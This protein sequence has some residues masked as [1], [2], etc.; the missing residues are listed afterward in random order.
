MSVPV[1]MFGLSEE[2]LLAYVEGT[3]ESLPMADRRRLEET[4]HE[5]PAL[6]CQLDL[7][8]GDRNAVR[9]WS[10]PPLDW[11]SEPLLSRASQAILRGEALGAPLPEDLDLIAG[12]S[13]IPRAPAIRISH[14]DLKREER[15]SFS[16]YAPVAA[17]LLLAC[18]AGFLGWKWL[19]SLPGRTSP[20]IHRPLV[21]QHPVDPDDQPATTGLFNPASDQAD[22]V[23]LAHEATRPA[24]R[25]RS[26]RG[27]GPALDSGLSV[28]I[29]TTVPIEEVLSRLDES[30]RESPEWAAD[31]LLPRVT[32]ILQIHPLKPD[33]AATSL[34]F[35]ATW[36]DHE[37]SSASDRRSELTPARIADSASALVPSET[38][39]TLADAGVR[40]VIVGR[41]SVIMRSMRELDSLPDLRTD[42]SGRTGSMSLEQLASM[43]PPA[44]RSWADAAVLWSHGDFEIG[45]GL[46]GPIDE[47]IIRVNLT[48]TRRIQRSRLQD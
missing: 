9:R 6:K 40:Y 29:E 13:D 34:T 26:N 11:N 7:L 39:V 14:R 17:S 47:P 5:I 21:Q 22:R 41:P 25:A 2:I 31:A 20:E 33:V 28:R 3:L 19:E 42:A 48:V 10:S 35:C 37:E 23:R 16:R 18:T 27:S 46:I 8:R 12:D 30:L 38:A 15:K 45:R 32:G 1:S 24:A 44:A 4:L 43:A 36:L